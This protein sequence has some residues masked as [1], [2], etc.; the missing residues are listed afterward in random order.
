MTNKLQADN[1]SKTYWSLLCH[2]GLPSVPPQWRL[3]SQAALGAGGKSPLVP[4]QICKLSWPSIRL[5]NERKWSLPIARLGA[6][7]SFPGRARGSAL[8][9]AGSSRTHH[10]MDPPRL[11]AQGRPDHDMNLTA[12]LS[13]LTLMLDVRRPSAPLMECSA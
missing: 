9:S 3:A 6:R 2:L 10:L 7:P 11:W 4:G 1:V 8:H 13:Q 5:P 12:E